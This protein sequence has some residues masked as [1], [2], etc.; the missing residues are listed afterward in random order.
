MPRKVRH[1]PQQQSQGDTQQNQQ[2]APAS[3]DNKKPAM[4]AAAV[5]AASAAGGSELGPADALVVAGAGIYLAVK[6]KDAIK[7]V[8]GQMVD[9]AKHIHALNND[10]GKDPRNH[11]RTEIRGRIAKAR[12]WTNRMSPGVSKDA[13]NALIN[14]VEKAVPED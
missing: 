13:M 1:P 4:G 6:N 10:P 2:P 8:M 7:Q 12:Q 14:M 3:V 9:A 11:W 5:L